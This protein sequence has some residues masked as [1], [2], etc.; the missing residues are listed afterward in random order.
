MTVS[1][2]L[3]RF[4]SDKAVL[5]LGDDMVKVDY[6]RSM[7]DSSL[8]EGDYVKINIEFDEETTE[9]ARQEALA[10]LED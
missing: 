2:Y 5:Y 7:L 6:P 9:A 3:D 8:N 1:G 10:L 4:E